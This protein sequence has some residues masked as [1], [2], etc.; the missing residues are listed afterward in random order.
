MDTT[1]ESYTCLKGQSEAL[2]GL[3]SC[4]LGA[5]KFGCYSYYGKYVKSTCNAAT[6]QSWEKQKYPAGYNVWSTDYQTNYNTCP[7]GATC[8]NP[9]GKCQ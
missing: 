1:G 2:C 4:T 6:V 5:E 7:P 9:E 8:Y 3:P